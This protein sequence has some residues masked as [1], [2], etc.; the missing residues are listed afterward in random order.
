MKR[1]CATSKQRWFDVA[2]RCINV[3]STSDT[4]VVSTLCNVEKPTSDFVSLSTSD[5][6]YFNVDPQCWNNVDP[7]S[8]CW[9]GHLCFLTLFKRFISLKYFTLL[10]LFKSVISLKYFA[11]FNSSNQTCYFN[12][13]R[14][15][16]SYLID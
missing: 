15:L 13:I 5:Q 8:K 4:D 9:L 1:R 2:Q 10:R 6:C 14:L 16:L 7:T 3:V 11:S 12:P